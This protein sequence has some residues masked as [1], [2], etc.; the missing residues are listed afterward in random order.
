MKQPFKVFLLTIPFML[1]KHLMEEGCKEREE[2]SF[3]KLTRSN[4]EMVLLE[5]FMQIDQIIME[6]GITLVA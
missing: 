6:T 2:C 5:W 3:L 4:Q 1:A